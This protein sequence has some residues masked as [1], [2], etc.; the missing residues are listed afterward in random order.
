MKLAWATDIHLDFIT[1]P[2][3]LQ[4]SAH[5][6]DLFCSSLLEDNPDCILL[7]GDISLSPHL[8]DHL[9]ALEARLDRSIYFVL[10]NHDFWDG[11][12]E[13]TR[14]KITKLSNES[15]YLHYISSKPCMM[16]SSR[17]ALV[18]HDG[19]YD[20][21]YGD[22]QFS[23]VIL[24]DWLRISDYARAGV[25]VPGMRPNISAIL[26][27]SRNQAAMAARHVAA[28]IKKA[29]KQHGAS[30]VVVLTHVPPFSECHR[31]TPK[32]S[33]AL[34]WYSSKAMGDM[35]L[36]AAKSFSNVTFEV[37]CGHSHSKFDDNITT[38]LICHVG[39]AQYAHPD[40]QGIFNFL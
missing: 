34:P 5:N 19:W 32:G 38:N 9:L 15:G 23:N 6:L 21:F 30:H 37:F 20:G 39:G 35:L 25:M 22:A 3:Q 8:Q 28:G 40:S 29:I 18:G 31:D 24:N 10:G 13:S 33:E 12:F 7:S 36:S 27:I 4:A 2:E 16:L 1:N 14:D 26:D 17:T 11:S